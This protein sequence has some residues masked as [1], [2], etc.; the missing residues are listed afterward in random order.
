[1]VTKRIIAG[2]LFLAVNACV[3]GCAAE[4]DV[5][6]DAPSGE[7]RETRGADIPAA[8]DPASA[9]RAP[10]LSWSFEPASGDCNGW[11]APGADAI[12]AS[13]ARS[14]AYSC[15]VCSDG[16]SSSLGL[17]RDLGAASAGRYVLSAWVRKRA[18]N[19]APAEALAR[20]DAATEGGAAVSAVAP[21]VPVRDA[22]DR[23]EATLDL[24][25][26]ATNVR[27]TIAAPV[28]EAGRCLFVDDVELERR[29]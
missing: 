13:P 4:H 1:M 24:A 20:I 8:P 17:V 15:K 16:S 22:W 3:L 27:V 26:D 29:R 25:T 10:L 7:P 14:G 6:R 21:A 12:R 28:D 19:A 11:P 2:A 9:D 5:D 18:A 23:L